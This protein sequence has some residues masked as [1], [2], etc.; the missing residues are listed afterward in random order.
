MDRI[1]Y[2][3]VRT[4]VAVHTSAETLTAQSL[5]LLDRHTVSSQSSPHSS[6]HQWLQTSETAAPP[7][8]PAESLSSSRH[9]PQQAFPSS[10]GAAMMAPPTGRFSRASR[11]SRSTR[12]TRRSA[13]SSLAEELI[14]F[15]R[16]MTGNLVQVVGHMQAQAQQ[17][18]IPGPSR[19]AASRGQAA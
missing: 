15:S 12:H 14:S 8:S 16:D 19:D 1:Q 13:V 6:I 3:A 2:A 11:A 10:T 5:R 7:P 9:E 18:Q 17:D 4:D